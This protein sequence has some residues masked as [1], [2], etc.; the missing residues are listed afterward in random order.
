MN[1]LHF[2]GFRG[3]EYWS[4]VKVFGLPDVIHFT[5]D[6]RALR[7]VGEDDVI[8]FANKDYERLGVS[9]YNYDDSNQADDP[10]YAERILMRRG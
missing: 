1:L 9:Q 3:E 7:E 10:A 2:V 6:M 5:W 4:A 8:V